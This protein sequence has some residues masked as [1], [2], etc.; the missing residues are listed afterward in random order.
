MV[1]QIIETNML[2]SVRLWS[3]PNLSNQIMKSNRGGATSMFTT[4]NIQLDNFNTLF[5]VKVG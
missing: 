2:I 5:S 3:D 4:E 1:Q